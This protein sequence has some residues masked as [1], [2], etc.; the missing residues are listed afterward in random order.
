ME[1]ATLTLEQLTARLGAMV[2]ASPSLRDVWVTA[3]TSDLRRSNHCY[4]ELLQKDARTGEPVAR[5]RATIWRTAL[6]RIDAAFTAMT[7]S[8]LESGMK[9]RVLVSVNYHP[10]YGL[11]LNIT[12]IDPA[13]TMGDLMRLRLEILERLKRE[14]VIDLNRSLEWPRTVQR[15]AVISAEGAAGY[16]DF[17]H[18]L[19]GNPRRLRFTARLFP[20]MMQGAR[21][22]YSIISALEAIAAEEEM[23]D[24]VVIIRG[25]GATSDLAAF[26][27]YDLAA[28]I[29]QFPLPV[30]IG[31][32][33]ERDITVLD[34]VA[35]MR[36]KTPTA[37]AEWLIARGEAELDALDGLA[38]SIHHAAS[39]L[40]AGYR[41]QLAYLSAT[42]PYAP[43]A[44]ID[45]ARKRLDRSLLAL[46]DSN[47]RLIAPQSAALDM[48]AER[49]RNA[50]FSAVERKSQRLDAVAE[51]L[52]VLSPE[53]T[54]RRG[55][56]I[57]RVGG[58]AVTS[59]AEVASGTQLETTL[60]SGI[61]RS[62]AD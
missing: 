13:Y 57:T 55:Y 33:H 30:V 18:Q 24:A 6:A 19:F 10:S 40:L 12:D 41:E 52:K 9:I 7:G 47:R 43:A 23:W 53:A 2:N 14:G 45:K 29:A 37:A 28:N 39:S 25:G 8:R 22:P 59:A 38:S 20:A 17:M 42:L 31:I 54:L 15:V 4:L 1:Q 61:L 50:A 16:G 48:I 32:G 26:E 49:I 35:N 44:A 51:L 34:Y 11:S 60:A 58:R 36:V 21:A 62:T 3:E 46:S 5:M 27:N 56:S